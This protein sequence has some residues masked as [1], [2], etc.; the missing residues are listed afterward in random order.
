MTANN[1]SKHDLD[2]KAMQLV[3]LGGMSN[4]FT[5]HERQL[6]ENFLRSAQEQPRKCLLQLHCLNV[7]E[8]QQP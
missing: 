8:K 1:K 7:E 2:N 3:T 5:C 6:L 4:Q